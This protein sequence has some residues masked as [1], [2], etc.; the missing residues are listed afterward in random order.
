LA[1]LRHCG[2]VAYRPEG[3]Q[4]FYYLA[5][6]ELLDLLRAAEGFLGATGD[7]VELCPTYGIQADTTRRTAGSE[8]ARA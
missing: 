8:E 1:C 3:R 7:A 2:L 5:R 6:P 4:S